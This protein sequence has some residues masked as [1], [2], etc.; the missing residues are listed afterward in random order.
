MYW[1]QQ[2]INK[3]KWNENTYVYLNPPILTNKNRIKNFTEYYK[4]SNC[5][6]QMSQGDVN[7]CGT[8]QAVTAE[9]L[10]HLDQYICLHTL[11]IK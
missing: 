7:S 10:T 4:G 8:E 1:T 5:F 11:L 6:L 2:K 9:L 3:L